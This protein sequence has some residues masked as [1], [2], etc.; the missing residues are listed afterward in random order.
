MLHARRT[1]KAM[2]AGLA[3]AAVAAAALPARADL[4]ASVEADYEITYNGLKVGGFTFRS[5]N[6]AAGYKMTTNGKVSV[7][8]GAFKW[9]AHAD[10][11]GA[12]AKGGAAVP[13]D[14]K[15]DL[16][17]KIKGGTTAM[18]FQ[19]GAVAKVDMTPPPK[20]KPE[21]IPVEPQHLKGVFDPMAAVMMMTRGGD[22][23]CSRKVPVFDGT[24]RLDVTL[25][26]QG[27]VPLKTADAAGASGAAPAMGFVCRVSYKLIA[28]HKPGD[29]NTYMNKNQNI[30]MVLRPVPAANVYVPYEVSASTLLGPIRVMAK[31]VTITPREPGRQQVVLLH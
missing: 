16:K 15:F 19:N 13:A 7:L 12:I 3:V 25:S 10:A 8:F 17:G 27:E 29:E 26:P 31:K 11:S 1:G 30:E 9:T 4:P 22:N 18:A 28:G 14:F 21:A 20:P 2:T 5:D 6:A 24:R 23:P